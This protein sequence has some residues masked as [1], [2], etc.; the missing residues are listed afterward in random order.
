MNHNSREAKIPFSWENKPGVSKAIT[1]TTSN[2]FLSNSHSKQLPPPPCQI[3]KPD[4]TISKD[5]QNIPLPPCTFQPPMRSET[6]SRRFGVK[7]Q[8]GRLDPF[9]AA[10]EECTRSSRKKEKEGSVIGSKVKRGV[11]QG[12]SCKHSCS[13]N[14]NDLLVIRISRVPS[15][16]RNREL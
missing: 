10:Y 11:L 5:V 12:L 6:P 14:E 4:F 1:I 3:K 16:R 15:Q 9:R 2:L 8:D 13:V 7:M